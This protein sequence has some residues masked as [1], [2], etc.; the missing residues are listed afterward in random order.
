MRR[1]LVL[2]LVTRWSVTVASAQ[3]TAPPADSLARFLQFEDASPLSCLFTYFPPFFI[4]NGIELK[5]FIRSRTFL[6]LRREF[7]DRR[8][9]DAIYVRAMQMTNNNTAMALL[10]CSIA[11][12]DHRL[13]GIKVPIF[14]LYLPLSNESEEEFTRRVR[15][16]PTQLYDDTPAGE[17]GDRDKLQHFFGSAF[18]AFVFE[19]GGAAT[20]FGE[21][22]EEGEEAVVIGGVNDDRDLRA[23]DQGRRF[24]TAALGDNRIYPSRYFTTP[25][26]VREGSAVNDVP[27]CTGVW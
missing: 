12:F 13:V 17:G 18:L 16:L 26:P 24:G 27:L 21:F 25:Q 3:S 4:Q 11:C 8:A 14:D 10:L 20:R 7:G 1:V 19:S 23:D 9:A 6:R 15:H 22:V 5:S 2:I